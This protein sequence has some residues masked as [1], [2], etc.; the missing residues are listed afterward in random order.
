MLG[1]HAPAIFLLVALAGC[2]QAVESNPPRTATE[3]MLI[4]TAADRAAEKLGTM[5]QKD[6]RVFVD[7]SNFDGTDAKYAIGSIRASLM[8]QGI[9]LVDDRKKARTVVEVRSGALST[10]KSQTLVG[11]PSFDIPIPLS[12]SALPF[13]ELALYKNEDQKGVAKFV[14]VAYDAKNGKL[15]T[16]QDPQYGYAHKTR[17]K[18]LFFF[19]WTEN[20]S[21]PEGGADDAVTHD[22]KKV[23]PTASD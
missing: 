16:A 19:T 2:T 14:M 18:V 22:V 11:I 12:S 17:R 4:S 6:D 9:R 8:K 5:L 21:L 23:V 7:A 1:K 13:P 3:Q 20:D 15:I 10:D